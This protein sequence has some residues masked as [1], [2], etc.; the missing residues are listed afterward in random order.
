[1]AVPSPFR[2]TEVMALQ[3]IMEES[4]KPLMRDGVEIRHLMRKIAVPGKPY[5]ESF[6]A[7]RSEA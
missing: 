3:H 2:K 5:R 1:M 7:Q 4:E 6:T